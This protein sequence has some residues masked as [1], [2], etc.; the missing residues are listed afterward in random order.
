VGRCWV[1]GPSACSA[2]GAHVG[3]QPGGWATGAGDPRKGPALGGSS[4]ALS[5]D[6]G[7]F[8]WGA[9]RSTLPGC[10]AGVSPCG[11]PLCSGSGHRDPVASGPP[12]HSG[13]PKGLEAEKQHPGL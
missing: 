9:A 4:L 3:V 11:Q 10:R 5:R 1:P 7:G 6:P 13:I 2:A 12:P 8:E